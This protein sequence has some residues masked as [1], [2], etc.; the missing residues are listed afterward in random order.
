M[1]PRSNS[2]L[3]SDQ[4]TSAQ[5]WPGLFRR[6][7]YLRYFGTVALVGVLLLA[8]HAP[9]WAVPAAVASNRTFELRPDAP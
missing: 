1:G 2:S 7:G 9:S 6:R 5:S 4:A 3:A 8:G